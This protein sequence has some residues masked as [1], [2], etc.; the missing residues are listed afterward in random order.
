MSWADMTMHSADH[1]LM[2]DTAAK[3]DLI[4]KQGMG[5]QTEVRAGQSCHIQHLMH[6]GAYHLHQCSSFLPIAFR[7]LAQ[8]ES[9]IAGA[10]APTE[11]KREP[12]P[13]RRVV[14]FQEQT[15]AKDRLD[16]MP[17]GDLLCQRVVAS[18]EAIDEVVLAIMPD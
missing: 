9:Q 2:L 10:R 17:Q 5:V 18:D 15:E 11:R 16:E 4:T 6:H 7:Q 13:I 1:H 14:L 12:L 3:G 8:W